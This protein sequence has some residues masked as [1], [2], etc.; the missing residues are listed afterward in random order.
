MRLQPYVTEAATLCKVRWANQRVGSIG[1]SLRIERC[2]DES[3]RTGVFLLQM[4]RAVAPECV[5]EALIYAG[6]TQQE[7]KLNAKYGISCAQ[8]MGCR[9]FLT[10]EDIAQVKPSPR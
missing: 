6:G 4:L 9:V 10:W 5:D 7:R 1:S 8:K 2:G 3:V